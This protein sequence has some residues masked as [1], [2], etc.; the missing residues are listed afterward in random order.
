MARRDPANFSEM[1][2]GGRLTV[3]LALAV[4]IWACVAWA[5]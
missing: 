2:A 3:A 1:G 4:V 5:A